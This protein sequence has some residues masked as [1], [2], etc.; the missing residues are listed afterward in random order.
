M[1]RK[2]TLAVALALGGASMTAHGLGLGEIEARSVLNQNFDA[3]I[4]LLSVADEELDAVRVRLA[5][6]EAF[7]RAGVE[8]GFLLTRLTF[9]PDVAA[10]GRAVIRVTSDFPIR[11]PFLNFLVEVNWPRGRLVREY[12]VLLDPPL[13]TTRRPPAVAAP[14]AAARPQARAPQAPVVR[15]GA[16]VSEYGPVQANETLWTI[17]ERVRPDAGV[18]VTQVMM[19][20]LAANPQ[21]FVDGNVNNLLRGQILRV[22]SRDEMLGISRAEAQAMF[23]Q[24]QDEWLAQRGRPPAPAAEETPTPAAAAAAAP[25]ETEV[26]AAAEAAPEA[27]PPQDQLRIAS[28]RPG[29]MDIAPG[30]SEGVVADDPALADLGNQVLLAREEAESTRQEAEALRVRIDRL[31][32]QLEDMQRLLTLKDDQLARLQAGVAEPAEAPLAAEAPVPEVAAGEPALPPEPEPDAVVEDVPGQAATDEAGDALPA[33]VPAE[34]E[35]LPAEPMPSVAEGGEEPVGEGAPA[36]IE[37]PTEP[38]E[39]I[40]G[41]AEPAVDEIVVGEE[42]VDEPVAAPAAGQDVAPAEEPAA[43]APV[44]AEPAP[45][46]DKPAFLKQLSTPVVAGAL[47]VVVLIGLLLGLLVARRGRQRSEAAETAAPVVVGGAA[48]AAAEPSALSELAPAVTEAGGDELDEVDPVAEADVYIAY[49]RYQQAEK[50]LREAMEDQPDRLALRHKLLEVFYATRDASGFVRLAGEMMADG[51]D[52]AD[53]A[54]WE[55]VKEMGHELD[56]ENPLFATAADVAAAERAAQA[57]QEPEGDDL[58]LD[59]LELADLAMDED[60]TPGRAEVGHLGERIGDI[61]DSFSSVAESIDEEE[62]ASLEVDLPPTEATR[63]E[64][65]EQEVISLDELEFGEKGEEPGSLPQGLEGDEDEGL[66]SDSMMKLDT[67]LEPSELEAELEK[68]TELSTLSEDLADAGE[69]AVAAGDESLDLEDAFG[70]EEVEDDL[71]SLDLY[72][73]DNEAAIGEDEV[74]T[75]LELASAYVDMGDTEGARSILEEVQEEGSDT[76]KENAARLLSQL[77]R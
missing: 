67:D 63:G 71:A 10:D 30:A 54:A 32:E 25:V 3:D 39:T 5:P 76:Q 56:P 66:G 24:Q 38:T 73:T 1:V 15:A 2:L 28:A 33:E 27:K 6:Q 69:A 72:D 31:R 70:Q 16:P 64:Q 35:V 41:S 12:T 11:E 4:A 53:P 45:V 68:L 47:G 26:D 52:Q 29:D 48:A 75:K 43:P 55:Q 42:P 77:S 46:D 61:E 51:K 18:S 62:L 9:T 58:G 36:A 23:R 44:V 7:E 19:A 74:Q 49:G 22:P 60:D 37:T 57:A 40:V 8:R 21:A 17:A 13:T 20:L 50:L 34:A 59:D 65:R 14:V